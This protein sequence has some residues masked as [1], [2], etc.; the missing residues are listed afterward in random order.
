MKIIKNIRQADKV[1]KTKI[2]ATCTGF[3]NFLW[4][5]IQFTLGCIYES[6]FL[7]ASGIFLLLIALSK[8]LCVKSLQKND[9][10]FEIHTI[11]TVNFLLIASGLFYAIYMLRL[12][13]GN[14][15]TSFGLIMSIAIATFSF[16]NMTIAIINLVK[17]RGK[18]WTLRTIRLISFIGAMTNI[19]L[20]Q[21]ALLMSQKPDAPQQ[22]NCYFGIAIG[23]FTI[24]IAIF[25]LHNNPYNH[26]NKKDS[27]S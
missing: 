25:N 15:P 5:T 7:I 23:C 2:I 17:T 12:L 11:K 26:K 21:M 18:T 16:V 24:F 19:L 1:K 27:F 10:V 14:L 3:I 6:L 22:F 13:F 9:K 8:F 20:T 4:S